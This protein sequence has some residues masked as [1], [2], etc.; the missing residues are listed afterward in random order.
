LILLSVG[1]ALIWS[2]SGSL[3]NLEKATV[4]PLQRAEWTGA[5]PRITLEEAVQQ[6]AP[7][8]LAWADDAR[9]VKV[10][11]SWRPSAAGVQIE[12][13]PVAWVLLYYSP[14]KRAIAA[15][16]V[17]GESFSWGRSRRMDVAVEALTPFPPPHGIRVAWLG[18]LAAGGDDFLNMH[19]EATVQFSL[20]R[21]A[22][23]SWN[24]LAFT[25][26]ARFEVDV[27]AETGLAKMVEEEDQ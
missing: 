3:E 26:Q 15:A 18:F 11:A 7:R 19:P 9:L 24:V 13:P 1:I 12:T 6:A 22:Q 27:D 2:I 21:K 20:R 8:A 17:H 23:L 10:T 4:V 5:S 16:H 25:P 14:T